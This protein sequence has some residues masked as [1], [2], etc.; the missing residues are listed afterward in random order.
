MKVVSL[1]I[2]YL[3][4]FLISNSIMFIQGDYKVLVQFRLLKI[5]IENPKNMQLSLLTLLRGIDFDIIK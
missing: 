2:T 4:V 3:H 5:S 1:C